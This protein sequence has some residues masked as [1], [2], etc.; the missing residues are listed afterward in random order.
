MKFSCTVVVTALTGLAATRES[1]AFSAVAPPSKTTAT[2]GAP[3]VDPVDK[4]MRH[5]DDGGSVFDPAAGLN[6]AL[7]RNNKGDVWVP[8]VRRV[9]ALLIDR[10]YARGLYHLRGPIFY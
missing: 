4:S 5:I 10:S 6:A 3:N 7:T 9:C 2:G 1:R 8:Q